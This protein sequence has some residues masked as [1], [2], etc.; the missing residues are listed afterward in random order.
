[1]RAGVQAAI[2]GTGFIAGVHA[3]AVRAA[4]GEVVA[5]LGSG[6]ATT[7]AGVQAMGARRG[8]ADLAELL[9]APEIDVVHICTPNRTHTEMALAALAAG[10]HVICEK[11]LATSVADARRLTEVAGDAGRV[12]SVPFVYRFYASVREARNRIARDSAGPLWLLHGTYL[13]DWL[14]AHDATNWRMDPA[15]GGASRAFGDIGV[16][17][18]DLMEFTTGHRITR[19]AAQLG[20]AYKERSVADSLADPGTEDGAVVVFQTDRGAM[21]SVVVSQVTPGRKNR[22]WFSFD[23]PDASYSFDQEAPEALFV[24]GR[25][26]NVVLMRGTDVFGQPSSTYSRLPAGHP[27]GYQDAFNAYVSDVYAAMDGSAPDGL[28]MFDDGLRAAVLTQAVVE[29]AASQTWI[30]VPA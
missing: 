16:H 13:Q 9:A 6:A 7:A 3:H 2:I 21:G 5:V 25:E 19:L 17:W 11:P 12:A 14:S 18:C 4:G 1:M 10:K 26:Q 23:G 24:G 22:L 28:P 30:E 27:Q 29:A 20:S 15:L 8:A